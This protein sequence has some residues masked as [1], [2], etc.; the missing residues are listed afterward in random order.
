MKKELGLELYELILLVRITSNAELAERLDFY[1]TFLA[2]KGSRFL[3]KNHG[4]IA[5]AYSIKDCSAAS[6]FQIIYFGN[7]ELTRQLN[8]EL[9]RDELVL[10]VITSKLI[11]DNLSSVAKLPRKS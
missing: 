3:F 1:K 9:H 7:G 2:E 4:K 6:Y 8:K 5:L 10:R 11:N